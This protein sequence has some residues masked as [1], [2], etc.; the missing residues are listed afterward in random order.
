[1]GVL[2]S[3]LL[4]PADLNPMG[5]QIRMAGTTDHPTCCLA[6]VC[7]LLELQA[8]HMVAQRLDDDEKVRSIVSTPGGQQEMWFVTDPGLLR[9]LVT[10]RLKEETN[11]PA[12][13]A[14]NDRIHRFRRWVFHDVLPAIRK[15]GRYPAPPAD[16]D[17]HDPIVR[18]LVEAKE[19]RLMQLDL[20]RRQRELEERTEAAV[21][22]A[23]AALETVTD[24]H[25]YYSILAWLKFQDRS[26]SEREAAQHGR[27]LTGAYEA[28]HG[29]KPPRVKSGKWGFINLYPESLLE[30]HFGPPRR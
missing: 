21:V 24:N 5:I 28:E 7:Q 1:M 9:I 17:E 22:L 12:V 10:V 30:S 11:D 19:I 26:I 14:R 27:M 20:S 13:A 23:R 18:S 8:P 4:V 25:G 6:D 2:N 3:Q 16:S 29:K 15:F